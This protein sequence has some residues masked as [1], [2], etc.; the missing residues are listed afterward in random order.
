MKFKSLLY[1]LIGIFISSVL[2]VHTPVYS[3]ERG[4]S[5]NWSSKELLVGA[6]LPETG[7]GAVFAEYIKKGIELAVSE[8]NKSKDTKIRVIYSDSKNDPKEGISVFNKMVLG[9]KPPII[10]TAL[11][12]VTRALAPLAKDND[13]IIIGT[14]VGLPDVTAPSNYV[15]RVY[16]EAHGL[17]GVVAEYASKNFKTAAVVYIDDDFGVS[18]AQVF[19]TVFE[20]N[21][22]KFLHKEPYKIVQ[23]DFRN[24]WLKI[25]KLKPECVWVTGYGPAYSVIVRQMK[26]LGIPSTLLADMT[27]GLPV[28]LKNVENAAEGIVYVDGVMEKDF[29]ERYQ[30][31]YSERPTSYAGYAYDIIGMIE[32]ATAGGY[33]TTKEIRDNLAEISD[34]S[35]AMGSITI[36]DSRDASLKFELMTIKNSTPMQLAR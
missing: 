25:Q 8:N 30:S 18:G 15:F 13:T 26:E 6:I 5:S 9:D 33:V 1:T 32:K 24:Q 3:A 27:L 20:K 10:I 22:G 17:A 14:A 19:Q 2:V 35:G 29:V 12:S 7:P 31:F 28:T 11:S 4:D 23:A 16:P 34:Y 36:L 21:G